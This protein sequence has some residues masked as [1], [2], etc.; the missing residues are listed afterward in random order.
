MKKSLIILSLILSFSSQV[1]ASFT[2]LS[3]SAVQEAIKEGVP[4]IDV[5]RPEEWRQYGVIPNSHLLTFFD[6]KGN[7][8]AKKWLND[9]SKIVKNQDDKFILVCAHANRTKTIGKF[10]NAKTDYKNVTELA[11]GIKHGWI[12]KGLATTK[13]P[14]KN[15]QNPWYKFW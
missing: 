10:L 1:M 14:A 11:G 9:L 8:D 12:N 4:I 15:Q 5:R 7:Y 3:T 6:S 2:T 13:I